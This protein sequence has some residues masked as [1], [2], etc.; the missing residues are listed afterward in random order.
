MLCKRSLGFKLKTRSLR[1]KLF[2]FMNINC[3]VVGTKAKTTTITF[4]FTTLYFRVS[5]EAL[6]VAQNFG[7]N[8]PL[9]VP[10]VVT[11]VRNHLWRHSSMHTT[12]FQLAIIIICI[13]KV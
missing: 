6:S 10:Y 7:R 1:F 5:L 13:N 4:Y 8:C 11:S 3:I 9:L 12:P 2:S